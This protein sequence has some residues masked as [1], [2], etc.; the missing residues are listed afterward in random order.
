MKGRQVKP[1]GLNLQRAASPQQPG[2]PDNPSPAIPMYAPQGGYYVPGGP[3]LSEGS[4]HILSDGSI[5]RMEPIYD[6]NDLRVGGHNEPNGWCRRITGG[7]VNEEGR[8]CFTNAN[9]RAVSY[10][11][12]GGHDFISGEQDDDYL[13]E[14]EGLIWGKCGECRDAIYSGA[15]GHLWAGAEGQFDQQIGAGVTWLA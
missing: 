2:E 11:G 3:R 1:V 7:A 10:W 4:R 12:L 9:T 14:G 5:S 6:S 8:Q 15:V 13:D